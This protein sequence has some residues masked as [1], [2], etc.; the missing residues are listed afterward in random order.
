M[1]LSIELR[2][3]AQH[4]RLHG[5]HVHHVTHRGRRAAVAGD[6]L[7]RSSRTRRGSRRGR[8]TPRARVSARKPCSPRSSRLRRGK[9]SSSSERFAFA[10]ISFSQSSISVSRS[11]FWRSV[12]TQSGPSRSRAPRTARLPTS[13]RTSFLQRAVRRRRAFASPEVVSAAALPSPR[14]RAASS[15]CRRSSSLDPRAELG[16]R[17]LAVLLLQLDPVGVARTAGA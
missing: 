1:Y 12:R 3:R 9:S 17:E 16:L 13:S 4:D 5:A 10:R 2:R 7:A 6:R 15:R 8:R 11:S 14:A